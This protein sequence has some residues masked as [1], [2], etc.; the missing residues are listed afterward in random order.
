[1]Y[2]DVAQLIRL[3]TNN[4]EVEETRID[5]FVNKKSVA[6]QEFYAVYQLG[7]KA[8]YAFE[9]RIEDYELSKAIDKF[10]NKPV[11][12][13]KIMYEGGEYDIIRTYEKKNGIIE[14]T[15]G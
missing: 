14:I 6:R 8:I 3:S 4:S 5:V 7:L 15:V 10:T 2:K 11:Y 9:M 13:T 1:L 12:A